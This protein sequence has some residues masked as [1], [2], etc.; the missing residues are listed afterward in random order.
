MTTTPA[1]SAAIKALARSEELPQ[2]QLVSAFDTLLSGEAQ[3][4]QVGAFLMGL[5][6]RGE[7]STRRLHLGFIDPDL[8]NLPLH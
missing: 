6:V 3:P 1:L 7:T 2:D 8:I 4:E 5:A